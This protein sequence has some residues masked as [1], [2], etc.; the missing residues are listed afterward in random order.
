MINRN[1]LR[2]LMAEKNIKQ[3]EMAEAI[4]ISKNAFSMKLNEKSRFDENEVYMLSKL[5]N[6]DVN[7]LFTYQ[8]D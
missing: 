5:L 3:G 6:V 1:K 4:G 2:G 8:V 7:F